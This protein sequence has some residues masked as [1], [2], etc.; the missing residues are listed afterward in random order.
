MSATETARFLVETRGVVRDLGA[1]VVAAR[2]DR[3][4][5]VAAFALG[6]GTCG[7]S[8]RR[9]GDPS[10]CT[11]ARCWPWHRIPAAGSC[12]AAMTARSGV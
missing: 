4:G 6:D 9:S 5:S 10:L 7:W 1:F 12:P 3:G 11:K 2:F 8:G